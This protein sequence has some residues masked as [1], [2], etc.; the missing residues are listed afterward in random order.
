MLFC[1]LWTAKSLEASKFIDLP[2]SP[3]NRSADNTIK[4]EKKIDAERIIIIDSE[5]LFNAEHDAIFHFSISRHNS[6]F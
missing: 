4:K 6:K 5:V 3:L 1:I 2:P